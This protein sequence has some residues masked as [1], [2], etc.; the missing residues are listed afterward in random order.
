MCPLQALRCGKVPAGH[1]HSSEDLQLRAQSEPLRTETGRVKA[2]LGHMELSK[3]V[4]YAAR[5]LGR[6]GAV[7]EGRPPSSA[8]DRYSVTS[9]GPA[10]EG[11]VP[12]TVE[13]ACPLQRPRQA[14]ALGKSATH[15]GRVALPG[16]VLGIREEAGSGGL[17]SWEARKAGNGAQKNLAE[18]QLPELPSPGPPQHSGPLTMLYTQLCCHHC[19][20]HQ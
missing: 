16:S 3:L 9:Q 7:L 20:P 11:A 17:G 8:G 18:S 4:W 5:L 15:G 10:G 1:T 13:G 12:L 19:W 6:L 14:L 2:N